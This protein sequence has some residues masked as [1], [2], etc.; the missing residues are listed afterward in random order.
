MPASCAEETDWQDAEEHLDLVCRLC[1][2]SM[3]FWWV[4]GVDHEDYT[5]DCFLTFWPE[6]TEI[7]AQYLWEHLLS[8]NH[9][10]VTIS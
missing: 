10:I 5:D 1:K 2:E 4:Q 3:E 7:Q 8:E 6:I 9:V